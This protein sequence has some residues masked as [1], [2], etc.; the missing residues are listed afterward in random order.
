MG[1]SLVLSVVM[2]VLLHNPVSLVFGLAMPL[3]MAL[4]LA[5][6]IVASRRARRE[7]EQD[8]ARVRE[9]YPPP[10]ELARE[11]RRGTRIPSWAGGTRD[12]P[13][14]PPQLRVGSCSATGEVIVIDPSGGICIAG[15]RAL[16]SALGRS[17]RA[18]T[19]WSHAGSRSFLDRE[20]HRARWLL[21]LESDARGSVIDRWAQESRRDGVSFDLMT[22]RD[23]D[24]FMHVVATLA[25]SDATERDWNLFENGPH[26]LVSGVT[27]AGKTVFLR[28]WIRELLQADDN[29]A[30]AIIDFKGGGA[31]ADFAADNRV[32]HLAT[33]LDERSIETALQGI[34]ALLARREAHL[35]RHAC[36]EVRD[37][38]QGQG[39]PRTVIVVD[40]FRALSEAHPSTVP[41]FND[42][43]ARGRALGVHLILS[44]QRFTSV[45]PPSLLANSALRVVFRAGDDEESRQL[46]GT[47]QAADASLASGAGFVR[48]A[49][50]LVRPV[51]VRLAGVDIDDSIQAGPSEPLWLE[52]LD[53]APRWSAV[54]GVSPGRLV[55]GL[56]A[57][58]RELVWVPVECDRKRAL[59]L[60]VG[61][62]ESQRTAMIHA[63]AEQ[64]QTSVIGRHSH[65]TWDALSPHTEHDFLALEDLDTAIAGVPIAWRD[66]FLERA[67]LAIRAT[68]ALGGSVVVGVSRADSVLSRLAQIPHQQ[69][70]VDA[71]GTARLGDAGEPFTPVEPDRQCACA[72]R[73]EKLIPLLECDALDLVISALPIPGVMASSMRTPEDWMFGR[74]TRQP[75]GRVLVHALSPSEARALRLSAECIPPTREGLLYEADDSGRWTRHACRLP[76][77]DGRAEEL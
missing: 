14:A 11:A 12:A 26:A 38:P 18:W 17:V 15:P 75:G 24:D 25:P 73:G 33:N 69:V 6:R 28:Q 50:G 1:I 31:F 77:G 30:I 62:R 21:Y 39:L 60:V 40:E 2:A 46:L 22:E 47:T 59:I 55:L 72:A 23:L 7:V 57:R 9:N 41:I 29:V 56:S 68:L 34:R 10:S 4:P 35:A 27:G 32:R 20:P 37:L 51:R 19:V 8:R 44:T 43:A 64:M 76:H 3:F 48:G 71:R 66:E 52:P 63:L 16:A 54:S 49:G 67:L 53:R 13:V 5:E 45:A 42:V 70:F 74:A 58:Q 61:G 65:E 36:L